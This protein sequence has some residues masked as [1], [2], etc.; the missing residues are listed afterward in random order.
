MIL[1]ADLPYTLLEPGF[2][3][4]NVYEGVFEE[5]ILYGVWEGGPWAGYKLPNTAAMSWTGGGT[6][7]YDLMV[8]S[9][10]ILNKENKWPIRLL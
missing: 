1:V 2:G 4:M 6:T 9:A 8:S 3:N 10:A 7:E 5:A